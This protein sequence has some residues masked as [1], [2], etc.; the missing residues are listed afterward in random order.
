MSLVISVHAEA[1]GWRL[2]GDTTPHRG[3]WPGVPRSGRRGRGG[4]AQP[5]PRRY[6]QAGRATEIH[7]FLRDG[8][9]AGRYVSVPDEQAG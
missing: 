3:A 5:G 2:Q 8:T 9:L 4:G 7:I 1:D 6:A